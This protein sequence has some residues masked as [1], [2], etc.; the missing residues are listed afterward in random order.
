MSRYEQ[1]IIDYENE[2]KA[3]RDQMGDKNKDVMFIKSKYEESNNL[4]HKENLEKQKIQLQLDQQ[5]REAMELDTHRR[6]AEE[7]RDGIRTKNVSLRKQ[8]ED[9]VKEN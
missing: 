3:L 1:A 6:R 9:L 4:W 5:F 7:D 8:I 2:N